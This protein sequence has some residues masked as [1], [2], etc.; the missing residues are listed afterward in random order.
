MSTPTSPNP[1]FLEQAR[2]DDF[3]LLSINVDYPDFPPVSPAAG[4]RAGA[5]RRRSEHVSTGPRRFS[6]KGFG[7]PGW[8]GAGQCRPGA[9]RGER[10][11]RGE[12]LE[13]RRPGG[14]ERRRQVHHA[15]RSRPGA[16]RR[17]RSAPLGV[18]LIDHQGEPHNCWLPLDQMTTD[19]D[20]EY[21]RHH[22]QYYMYLH[23]EQPGYEDLMAARDRF[24]AAHPHAA[25]RRRA[26]GQPGVRRGPDRGL[27]RPLSAS[28]RR[29]GGAH[30]PGA[31]PV[32]P[33]SGKGARSSSSATRTG[34][35]T[36]P[37]S[38]ST[39]MP[40]RRRSGKRRTACGPATGATSPPAKPSGST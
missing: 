37:T 21:F 4:C 15:R 13:E 18:P 22:P 7:T 12:D 1:A 17:A 36:A 34:C 39:R 31:V 27:P 8:A 23:P 19:N 5:C 11:A 38:R 40:I 26:P 6:M 30:E 10:R 25:L 35:C 20:R 24:V 3:E 29:H 16:R 2:A 28:Q 32:R 9:G 14:K 33:R